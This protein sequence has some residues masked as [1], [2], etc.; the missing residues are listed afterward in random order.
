MPPSKCDC[1]RPQ[2]ECVKGDLNR[3]PAIDEDDD[4]SIGCPSC[5]GTGQGFEDG[6]DCEECDGM[7]RVSL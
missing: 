7:G 4:E 5:A 6:Q 3:C 1:G 2:G